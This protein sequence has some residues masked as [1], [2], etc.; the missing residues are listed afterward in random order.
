MRIAGIITD[1]IVDGPGVRF[2]IFGQGCPHHCPACQN[3]E[4]WDPAGGREMSVKEIVKILKKRR[5][6]LHGVTFSGGE[7]FLQAEEMAKLGQ[8]AKKLNLDVVTYTGYRYE[9]LLALDIP[10]SRELLEVTDLLVDGPFIEELKDISL[11][12]RGSTNQRLI[13]LAATRKVGVLT[14]VA[15]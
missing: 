7:P 13:D 2:V 4:T 6:Y 15:S 5:N 3:P 11:P 8:E 10:G 1:S 12:F 14:L 9:E